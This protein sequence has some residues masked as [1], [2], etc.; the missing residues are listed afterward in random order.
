MSTLSQPLT[1][2]GFVD[3]GKSVLENLN[4]LCSASSCWL[5]YDISIGKW[6]VVINKTGTSVASFDDSNIIGAINVNGTGVNE[7][8]NSVSIEFPHADLR[9]QKDYI[10]LEIDASA[11]FENEVDNKLNIQTDL[12]NDPVTAQYLGNVEL[13]QSRV[14]K[15]IEFRTDYSKIGLK[16]GDLI[17]VTSSIYGY[18]NKVFRIIRIEE[19][20]GDVLSLSISALEYDSNVY[21]TSDLIRTE[22]TKRNGILIKT[23]N[24]SITASEDS[25]FSSNMSKMLLPLVGTGLLNLLFAKNPLTKKL[26]ASVTGKLSEIKATDVSAS[27]NVCE[28]ESIT[29]NVQ[30]CTIGCVNYDGVKAPYT[31]T[32]IQ[33]GDIDKPLT[34]NVTLNATGA[35]T[36]TVNVNSDTSEESE[37]MVFTCGG[38]STSVAIHDVKPYTYDV[39][40]SSETITEGQSV[41][42]TITTSGIA[43]G[44]SLPWQVTG[45]AT[46]SG[47]SSGN[48]TINSNQGSVTVTT[49]DVDASDSKQLL[50][51]VNPEVYNC[52]L[53]G[54]GSKSVT[55]TNTG[56][57][58]I[59]SCN[60]LISIPVAWC[61][62]SRDGTLLSVSPVAYMEVYAPYSGGPS[63]EVPATLTVSGGAITI[64]SKVAIDATSGKS[65]VDVNV[66]TSGFTNTGPII[67]GST[68]TVRGFFV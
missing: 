2:N 19:D 30:V 6:C 57:P 42:F 5:T 18:T 13:K 55:V 51:T 11:R 26:E 53:M 61:G 33:S 7:L 16:A 63:I 41:T 37:T 34:G 40:S 10:D 46:V 32:G 45:S 14:D 62:T 65:G 21:S 58:I 44:T 1:I 56:S 67:K 12:V 43:N 28:G 50:F 35:G 38:I 49:S 4:N 64:A 36:L 52:S 66:I 15:T 24:E 25:S 8:Y 27:L 22:R 20:D 29:F 23:M 54:D 39:V 3:T 68:T 48:V 9:D 17:D 47:S 31:I 59:S 60:N